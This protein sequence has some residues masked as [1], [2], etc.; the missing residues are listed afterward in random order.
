[1][2]SGKDVAR[3]LSMVQPA[4]FADP[5]WIQFYESSMREPWHMKKAYY[6]TTSGLYLQALTD[7]VAQY[8]RGSLDLFAAILPAWEQASFSFFGLRTDGGLVVSGTWRRG[9]FEVE[10]MPT[11]DVDMPVR[12]S[13]PGRKME[14]SDTSGRRVSLR[15]NQDLPLSSLKK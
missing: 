13:L 6:F 2:R 5:Y 7:C 10:I 1:M 3:D 15:G 11:R 12:V 4:R 8:C 14:L 9:S